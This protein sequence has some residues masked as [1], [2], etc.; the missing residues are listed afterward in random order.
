MPVVQPQ[1]YHAV[2]TKCFPNSCTDVDVAIVV[3]VGGVHRLRKILRRE[4]PR[5]P[6]KPTPGSRTPAVNHDGHPVSRNDD[7]EV[8][9]SIKI[10]YCYRA[11]P[12]PCFR[13]GARI[14]VKVSMP[15][16][17]QH[18]YD[19]IPVRRFTPTDD[20]VDVA[21]VV[22]VAACDRLRRPAGVV[23]NTPVCSRSFD[24]T[25][26]RNPVEIAVIRESVT[27]LANVE[28]PVAVAVTFS[29]REG[30]VRHVPTRRAVEFTCGS[31]EA[32]PER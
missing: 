12:S 19:A 11:G 18:R 5:F 22:D 25:R 15:I 24:I 28:H 2:G 16:I 7:V 23:P 31:S 3:E 21:V 1:L 13:I 26:I 29:A 20:Q 27:R 30:D 8:A 14:R 4:K 32:K 10:S 9:V 6:L 17:E